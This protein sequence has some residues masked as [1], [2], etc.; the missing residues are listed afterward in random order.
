MD[1]RRLLLSS[2]WLRGTELARVDTRS[3]SWWSS[4]RLRRRRWLCCSLL[5]RQSLLMRLCDTTSS[6]RCRCFLG[7]KILQ[8]GPQGRSEERREDVARSSGSSHTWEPWLLVCPWPQSSQ[9]CGYRGCWRHQGCQRHLLPHPVHGSIRVGMPD[10]STALRLIL[11][12]QTGLHIPWLQPR[13]LPPSSSC[14]GQTGAS[15]PL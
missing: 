10:L 12:A 5:E 3:R 11:S 8:E 9:S 1:L 2:S 7:M 15:H 4:L 14:Y 6:N 13:L